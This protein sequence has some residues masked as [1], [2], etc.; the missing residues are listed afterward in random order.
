MTAY[1]CK[2]LALF[3]SILLCPMITGCL[4]SEVNFEDV[5][6]T[7]HH[8]VFAGASA[9]IDWNN[10]QKISNQLCKDY[11]LPKVDETVALPPQEF[12]FSNI[13]TS[14]PKGMSTTLQLEGVTIRA[15]DRTTNLSFLRQLLLTVTD[16]TADD[17]KPRVVFDYT[18]APGGGTGNQAEL[19]MPLNDQE[20]EVDPCRLD[21]MFFE[22][23]TWVRVD[24]IPE[25]AWAI[26]V[27]LTLSGTIAIDY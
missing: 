7:R 12:S 5:R 16:E 15:H 27:T 9:D 23:S 2:S 20:I 24:E 17:G 21:T 8:L 25:E 26:D 4:S 13:K 11:D 3:G 14:L 6:V 19:S 22:L 10:I 18:N 1:C